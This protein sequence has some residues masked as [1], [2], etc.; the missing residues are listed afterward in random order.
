MYATADTTI[1]FLCD[2][3]KLKNKHLTGSRLRLVSNIPYILKGD[4]FVRQHNFF[5]PHNINYDPNDTVIVPKGIF[6]RYYRGD[7]YG[8]NIIELNQDQTYTFYDNS[9]MAHFTERGTWTLT[10][11][12]IDF[13]PDDK[14]WSMLEWVTQDKRLCL[15]EDYLIGKKTSRTSIGKQKSVVTEIYSYLSKMPIYPGD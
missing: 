11:G 6:A 5:I 3:S 8:S 9:C 15:V 12:V 7:G 13:T 1:Q 14:K 10:D 2:A 4:V